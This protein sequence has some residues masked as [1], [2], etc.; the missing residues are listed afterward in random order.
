MSQLNLSQRHTVTIR[1]IKIICIYFVLVIDLYYQHDNIS[2]RKERQG[3][4]IPFLKVDYLL[5]IKS[6]LLPLLVLFCLLCIIW[7]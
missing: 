5:Y 7:S 2:H 3:K 4:G 6:C 1:T